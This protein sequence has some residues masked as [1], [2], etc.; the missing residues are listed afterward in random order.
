MIIDYFLSLYNIYSDKNK[1]FYFAKLF[2]VISKLFLNI[3][4]YIIPIPKYEFQKNSDNNDYIISL[5]TFNK[6]IDKIWI[7][8]YSLIRE[9]NIPII[10]LWISNEEFKSIELLP[11]KLLYFQKKGFLKIFIVPGNIKSHKKYFYAIQ[12][13]PDKFVITMDD[14][15]IYPKKIITQLINESK[16]MPED[17]ICTFANKIKFNNNEISPY[18]EWNSVKINQISEKNIIQIGAGGCVYPPKSMNTKVLNNENLMRYAPTADDLWLWVHLRL[19][20]RK[21]TLI[22]P[23]HGL[24][25][26]FNLKNV[27]LHEK[28][29]EGGEN[30]LQLKL[31]DDYLMEFHKTTILELC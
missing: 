29:V 28:N 18:S 1:N 30:D 15:I 31:I 3:I 5:T 7:T 14:D 16:K 4:V 20:N 2:R 25:E 27:T 9:K 8:I 24:V 13:Y 17:I 22:K 12:T 6:R 11:K 26:V 10:T 21:V 23:Y 19:N